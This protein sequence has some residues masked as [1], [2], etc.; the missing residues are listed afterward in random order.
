M[1]ITQG[2]DT[3]RSETQGADAPRSVLS[4]RPVSQF[5]LFQRL[6]WRLLRN[7]W[8]VLVSQSSMR[9]MTILLCSAVVWVFVFSISLGGF[10]FLRF[11]MKLPLSGGLVEIL[12][13]LLFL[14]LA[15]LLVFSSGLILNGSLFTAA[16][17]N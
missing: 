7:S 8:E 11:D 13:D 17:T 10:R 14:A 12:L 5:L 3:P 2:T 16:E 6:R 1:S 15:T 4:Q 9:P